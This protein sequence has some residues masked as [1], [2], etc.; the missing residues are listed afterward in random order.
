MD[1]LYPA[2]DGRRQGRWNLEDEHAIRLVLAVQGHG[3]SDSKA[4]RSVIQ[5]R[6]NG[7]SADVGWDRRGVCERRSIVVSNGQV[8]LPLR[9]YRTA[10]IERAVVDDSWTKPGDAGSGRDTEIAVEDRKSGTSDGRPRQHRERGGR[11]KGYVA[12]HDRTRD[13]LT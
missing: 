5:P 7:R 12:L 9:R 8:G 11:P 1:Q 2:T 13:C 10:R 6:H 4:C 3:S